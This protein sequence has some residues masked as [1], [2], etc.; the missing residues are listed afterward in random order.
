M[1]EKLSTT[2]GCLGAIIWFF[3]TGLVAYL[4]FAM[5]NASFWLN[6]LL[7]TIAF[8]Y[9]PSMVIFWIWG[10]VCAIQGTQDVWSI[11]YYILFAV[12]FLPYYIS[13]VI[14]LIGKIFDR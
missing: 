12:L 1:K 2:L 9:R 5:I 13:V 8:F 7:F 14:E 3:V 4:P 10:L 11:I 6:L